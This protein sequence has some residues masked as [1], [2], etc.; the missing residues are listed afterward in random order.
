[1]PGHVWTTRYPSVESDGSVEVELHILLNN[2]VFDF[3]IQTDTLRAKT[4]ILAM[5][6]PSQSSAI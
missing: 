4:R 5:M 2:L 6:S 3:F 1:M